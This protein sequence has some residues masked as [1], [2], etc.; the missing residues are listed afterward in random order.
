MCTIK[1]YQNDIVRISFIFFGFKAGLVGRRSVRPRSGHILRK[2]PVP[3]HPLLSG[4]CLRLRMAVP[5]PRP[6]I[7]GIHFWTFAIFK[8]STTCDLDPFLRWS[9]HFQDEYHYGKELAFLDFGRNIAFNK[10]V[11]DHYSLIHESRNLPGHS[12][13]PPSTRNSWSRFPVVWSW[14][15]FSCKILLVNSTSIQYCSSVRPNAS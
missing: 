2:A 10:I 11:H 9:W 14:W 1:I 5:V 6:L 7:E 3:L 12:I 13:W 15:S 4:V 8:I